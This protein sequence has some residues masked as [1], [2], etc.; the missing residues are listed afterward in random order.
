MASCV[1]TYLLLHICLLI[2]KYI[3]PADVGTYRLGEQFCLSL[4]V[5]SRVNFQEMQT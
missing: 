2:L 4:L 5:I 3:T 1:K